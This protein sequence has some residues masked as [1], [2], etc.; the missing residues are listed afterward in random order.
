MSPDT[1]MFFRESLA[2]IKSDLKDIKS[3]QH[4]HDK[5]IDLIKY[6]MLVLA[7]VGGGGAHYVFKFLGL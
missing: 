4:R 1:V 2:E 6:K 7:G 5:Q 3:L